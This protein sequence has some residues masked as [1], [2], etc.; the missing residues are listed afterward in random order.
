MRFVHVNIANLSGLP[1]VLYVILGLAVFVRFFALERSLLS[2]A[3]TMGLLILPIIVISTQE[4]IRSIP[5]GFRENAFAL[6]A[7]RWQ[8]TYAHVRPRPARGIMTGGTRSL[9]RALRETA[10]P[11]IV[12]C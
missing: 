7:T 6:G 1:S 10:P 11:I 5:G 9:S 3:L 12:G 8:V 4:A 2:G